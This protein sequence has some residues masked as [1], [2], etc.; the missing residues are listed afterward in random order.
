MK[1]SKEFDEQTYHYRSL[2]V[3]IFGA[4]ESN[5]LKTRFRTRRTPRKIGPNNS[6]RMKTQNT[7]QN[8]MHKPTRNNSETNPHN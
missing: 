4:E 1:A 3:A 5:K 7:K 8:K 2:I 6:D